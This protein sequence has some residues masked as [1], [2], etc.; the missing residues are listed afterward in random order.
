MGKIMVD[1]RTAGKYFWAPEP[2]QVFDESGR[3]I[4]IFHPMASLEPTID[5]AEIERRKL[6]SEEFTTTEVLE[7]LERL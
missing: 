2:V 5:R 1:S 3:M 4:G 7:Y 6:D